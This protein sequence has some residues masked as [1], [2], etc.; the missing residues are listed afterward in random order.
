MVE[1]PICKNTLPPC[2]GCLQAQISFPDAYNFSKACCCPSFP[3]LHRRSFQE[4]HSHSS[5]STFAQTLLSSCGLNLP[6]SACF[7]KDSELFLRNFSV[8]AKVK[9]KPENS[10][11]IIHYQHAMGVLILYSPLCTNSSQKHTVGFRDLLLVCPFELFCVTVLGSV[12][13]CLMFFF[14]DAGPRNTRPTAWE[15][16]V[17]TT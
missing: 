4:R 2:F 13:K 17:A 1:T 5:T 8:Q 9:G 12:E 15:Y 7:R 10:V 6:T 14:L 11:L 16:N 3:L